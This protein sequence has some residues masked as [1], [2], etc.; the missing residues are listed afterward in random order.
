MTKKF[1]WYTLEEKDEYGRY[2]G[3]EIIG[4]GSPCAFSRCY[5]FYKPNRKGR[6]IKET[7]KKRVGK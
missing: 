5:N 1:S 4:E 7:L 2:I 3:S 6:C